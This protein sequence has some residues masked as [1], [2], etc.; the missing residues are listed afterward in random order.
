MLGCNNG[1]GEFHENLVTLKHPSCQILMGSKE[2]PQ[3]MLFLNAI[4][5]VASLGAF[6]Q[7]AKVAEKPHRFG[8][9]RSKRG[10]NPNVLAHSESP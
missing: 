3:K 9:H 6:I 8:R 10:P 1:I 5:K 4:K 2:A 7:N